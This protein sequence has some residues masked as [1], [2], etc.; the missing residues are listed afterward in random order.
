[1]TIKPQGWRPPVIVLIPF[2]DL[3]FLVNIFQPSVAF[4]I[5]TSRLICSAKQMTG[6]YM[7]SKTA[8]QRVNLKHSWTQDV[9]W[10]QAKRSEDVL[11]TS[12]APYIRSIYALR[13][14]DCLSRNTYLKKVWCSA[15]CFHSD[16]AYSL[17]VHKNVYS[18]SSSLSRIAQLKILSQN[19]KKFTF[20]SYP[21]S[22]RL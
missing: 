21:V 18:F 1:M 6:F 3:V 10:K 2:Y 7:K 20:A 14:E 22:N 17:L 5:E 15:Q 11:D 16:F 13:P 19:F 12:W 4:H 9:N 8:L